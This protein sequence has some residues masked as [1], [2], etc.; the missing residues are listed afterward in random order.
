M[1]LVTDIAYRMK[2]TPSD[3][4]AIEIPH[5]LEESFL[6]KLFSNNV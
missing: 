2:G 4:N 6:E 5:S 1:F 3:L